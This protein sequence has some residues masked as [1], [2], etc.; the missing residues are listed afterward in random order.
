MRRSPTQQAGSGRARIPSALLSTVADAAAHAV[1]A[2]RATALHHVDAGPDPICGVAIVEH[3]DVAVSGIEFPV[4]DRGELLG[5]I[6]VEMPAG[7][8]GCAPGMTQ[9]LADLADQAGMAFRT[10]RLTAELS[11]RVGAARHSN[12]SAGRVPKTADQHR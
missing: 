7:H 8:G 9:L 12:A 5:S 3:R 1:N 10:A 4:V 11:G 6:T 2:R